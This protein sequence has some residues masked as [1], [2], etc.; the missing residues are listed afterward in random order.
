MTASPSARWHEDQ[1]E[2]LRRLHADNVPYPQIAEQI[3]GKTRNAVIGMANR[4]GLTRLGPSVRKPRHGNLA[5][6]SQAKPPT[7]IVSP[8]PADQP[9]PPRMIDLMEL[10][11]GDCRFPFGDAPPYRFCANPA[12][13]GLPYCAT[14]CQVAFQARSR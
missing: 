2:T 7:P 8:K 4:L 5:F 1:L 14:H 9:K 11:Y 10:E 13:D 3:P 6:G 12:E